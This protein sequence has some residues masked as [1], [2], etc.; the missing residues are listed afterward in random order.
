MTSFSVLIIGAGQIGAFFDS[1]AQTAVLTHGH[2]FARHP[3]FQPPSFVDIDQEKAGQAARIWGGKAYPSID[4][5]FRQGKFDVA[6]VAVPDE[7]HYE[8]LKQLVAHPVKCVLAEKPLAK[9]LSQAT[10][11][12]ALYR[13]CGIP[14]AVNY[15]R[16]FVPEFLDLRA[17]IASGEFGE[18]LGGCG[19]Y[20]KGTLHNGSHL[21]DL[22][23]FLLGEIASAT[24]LCCI[25]DW[26]EADPSWSAV[27]DLCCGGRVMLQAVD[28]RHYTIFELDLLFG[29]KRVRMV[30][31]GFALE[32]YDTQDSSMFQGYRTLS[33]PTRQDTSL[34]SAFY[35]AADAIH[36]FLTA[37]EPLPCTAT[38]GV[39]A[40]EICSGISTVGG[41]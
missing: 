10:K 39:K 16:R 9:T 15:M 41:R 29:R 11:I 1:P 18:F 35:A 25:R 13:D 5:A 34:S 22:L 27:L 7:F 14:I 17:R 38:D 36:A 3:G 40:I 4:E 19:Y 33:S 23:R 37:G 21:V 26:S 8:V 12:S 6:V 32:L 24:G 28:C 20:G 2:A 30:D 31:S